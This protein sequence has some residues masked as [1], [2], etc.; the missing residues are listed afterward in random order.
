MAFA[1][2]NLNL[3]T[4]AKIMA[5][6]VQGPAVFGWQA[7]AI[8]FS[9]LHLTDGVIRRSQL[10]ALLPGAGP[11]DEQVLNLLLDLRL[12]DEV[13]PGVWR[14]HDF[15]DENQSREEREAMREAD[16]ARKRAA[17]RR[18]KKSP[19]I[20]ETAS[21]NLQTEKKRLRKS[22]PYSIEIEKH[23]REKEEN[24]PPT[25]PVAALADAT[26]PERSFS[27]SVMNP[28]TTEDPMPH[29]WEDRAEVVKAQLQHRQT[30]GANHEPAS[31][32]TC[33]AAKAE[34]ESATSQSKYLSPAAAAYLAN[35]RDRLLAQ[36][37]SENGND[38]A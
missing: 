34:F 26:K 16:A 17:Y 18:K 24:T 1:R 28:D 32:P 11:P 10:A 25:P 7:A 5:A 33:S 21:E 12:W 22:P 23:R 13:S 36:R 3:P 29:P 27:L 38:P 20:S 31:C 15:D 30:A 9:N 6:G 2:I 35:C 4:H 37:H 8:C 19:K 14:I